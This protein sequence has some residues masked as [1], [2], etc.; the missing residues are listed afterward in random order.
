MCRHSLGGGFWNFLL[1]DDKGA[2]MAKKEKRATWFK[3]FLSSKA[4]IDAVPDENAGK[5]LKAAFAYFETGEL[6]DLDP[7]SKVVFCAMRPYIDEALEDYA[8]RVQD[9]ENGADKRWG[10]KM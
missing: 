7:L 10:K 6:P 3:C 9:G 2:E 4:T 8:A 5:G 1:L